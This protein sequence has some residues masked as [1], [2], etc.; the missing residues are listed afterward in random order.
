M[1]VGQKNLNGTKTCEFDNPV[2]LTTRVRTGAEFRVARNGRRAG[3]YRCTMKQG[4][5]AQ[6]ERC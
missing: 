1:R 2:V 6:S 4:H 5:R 3:W